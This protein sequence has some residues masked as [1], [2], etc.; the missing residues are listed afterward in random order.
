MTILDIE[1]VHFGKF[2]HKKI[3]FTQGLNVVY[4]SNE[5]GKST[6]H[7]F[8]RCMLLGMETQE[9]GEE[10]RF[11]ERY[12]PW[13]NRGGY[14]GKLRLE[15]DGRAYRIER[16]FLKENPSMRLFD[17]AVGKEFAQPE[18]KLNALLG[19]LNE[20]NFNNTISIEQLQGLADSE[21]A[22]EL[23]RFI[24][25]TSR[26]KNVSIDLEKAKERLDCRTAE[27]KKRYLKDADNEYK[28]CD[29]K[30]RK[31]K[32]EYSRAQEQQYRQERRYDELEQR[33]EDEQR[34][35]AEAMLAYERERDTRR[36]QYEAAKKNWE[37]AC[38]KDADTRKSH[39]TVFFLILAALFAFGIGY[40]W[41]NSDL[42]QQLTVIA[43][44][45]FAAA[46]ALCI[47]GVIASF[48]FSARR[49]K[50]EAA[51]QTVRQRLKD[52]FDAS[53]QRFESCKKA[54]PADAQETFDRMHRE[55]VALKQSVC[56][57][58]AQA[59]Q[60]KAECEALQIRQQEIRA[61]VAD[62][63]SI[64]QELEALAVARE[65][66]DQVAGRV[67]ET[68]GNRLCKEAARILSNVTGGRYDR[69]Q[70][71]EKLGI[72]IGTAENM[73]PLQSVSRGTIEQVYLGIRIAAA[74]LLWQKSSMPFI[75]DDVFAY[76]DDERLES[77][78]NMLKD[79]GHQVIIFSCNTR[80]DR[81]IDAKK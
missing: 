10:N 53:A 8:I 35:N 60:W 64:S 2:H 79:C 6:I 43:V 49:R 77:A 39:M 69:I 14:G 3:K 55:L 28:A 59:E 38:G 52:Q 74:G 20:T 19:G 71:H 22:K 75:F 68:F 31:A 33:I 78:M 40:L 54:A 26:T 80:E 47:I 66:M 9:P 21:S 44:A 63:R 7:A 61:R 36:R 67:Q 50:Q 51:D 72:R 41:L 34:Q 57:N 42:E 4:G 17:E 25:N 23:E 12:L 65:T 76:Y 11:Y 5:A 56:E 45:G 24:L 16:N 30:L 62:N 32:K 27:L 70:I 15:I 13:D 29:E 37:Q 46:L 58:R 1:L 48:S 18:A 81:L 73:Y